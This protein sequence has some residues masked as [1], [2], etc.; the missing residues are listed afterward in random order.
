MRN[1]ENRVLMAQ[2]KLADAMIEK[3]KVNIEILTHNVSGVA[4]HPNLMKTVEDELGKIGHWEEIK[5]VIKKHF[6][7]EGK[8]TL[9][10]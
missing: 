7:F 4:D 6:D 10:E 9:T 5:S 8:R 1:F 2:L 3:H